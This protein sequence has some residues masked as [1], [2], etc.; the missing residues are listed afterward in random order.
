MG[1]RLRHPNIVPI[2]EVYSK[3]VTH[4]LA[5]E[6]VEGRN[7]REF[8]KTRKK[9][10]P[11]E[12]VR[13]TADIC[14]GMAYAFRLGV[15][16]RDLRMTNVL[17]SSLGIPKL[18]DFGLATDRGEDEHI[19]PRT[20]DYAGLERAT[21]VRKDDPRS[22]IFFLGC[23]LY[24]L[25]TG[26]APLTETRDRIQRLARSRYLEIPPVGRLEPDLPAPVIAVVGRAMETNADR[27]YQDPSDMLSDL[28]GAAHRL[29]PHHKHEEEPAVEPDAEL[30]SDAT[31]PPPA[32]QKTVMVVESNAGVQDTLRAGLKRVGYKVLMISDPERALE[33]FQHD[34]RPPDCVVF[35]AGELGARAVEAFNRFGRDEETR[36]KPAVL[37]LD[38]VQAHLKAKALLNER[39]VIVEMPIKLREFR[40][41]L[42]RLMPSRHSSEAASTAESA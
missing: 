29:D 6:F 16:H 4:Y 10:A 24:H 5:M 12:A 39:R 11:L 32:K 27:R 30:L 17:I 23:I 26:K 38:A 19:N 31:I 14:S 35:S 34:A 20:I 25:L 40:T 7:L 13:I 28:L 9:L 37:L 2:Y 42:G 3:G 36:D 22:D 8:I 21:G 15:S 1:R 41:A 18:V 33:R